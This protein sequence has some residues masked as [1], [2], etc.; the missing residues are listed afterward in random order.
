MRLYSNIGLAQVN[1]GRDEEN[2]V[3]V[4]ITN[5]DL[6]VK[7]KALKERVNWNLKLPLEKIFKNYDLTGT[8]VGVAFPFRCSPAT[9]LLI[10]QESHL[11]KVIER[12]RAAPGLLPLLGHHVG[13]LLSVAFRHFLLVEIFEL[14]F[15]V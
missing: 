5:P 1:E 4:Q 14:R 12:S 13:P 8:R 7:K 6:I 11:D 10:V 9:E 3:W 2:G 15:G